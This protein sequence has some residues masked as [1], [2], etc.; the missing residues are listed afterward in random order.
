L[1]KVLCGKGAFLVGFVAALRGY[2]FQRQQ[3]EEK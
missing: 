1:W 3:P 2:F